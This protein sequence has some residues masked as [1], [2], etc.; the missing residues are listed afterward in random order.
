[1]EC[2]FNNDTWIPLEQVRIPLEAFFSRQDEYKKRT[3]IAAR[4]AISDEA[5]LL[6]SRILAQAVLLVYEYEERSFQAFRSLTIRFVA[7]D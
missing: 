3:C 7:R 4:T 2:S 5:N 6:C 1:M